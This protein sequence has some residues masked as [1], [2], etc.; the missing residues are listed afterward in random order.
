MLFII[1]SMRLI[2]EIKL[3]KKK[4]TLKNVTVAIY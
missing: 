3:I 4:T 1:A 2:F